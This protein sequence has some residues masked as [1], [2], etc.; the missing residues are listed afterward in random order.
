M[1]Q[2]TTPIPNTHTYTHKHT[3]IKNHT[4]RA[5]KATTHV[6]PYTN[7]YFFVFS[8]L[9]AE[10]AAGHRPALEMTKIRSL[11]QMKTIR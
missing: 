1:V 8:S 2:N 5:R 3:Q 6:E 4:D 11:K 7:L 10:A 9:A